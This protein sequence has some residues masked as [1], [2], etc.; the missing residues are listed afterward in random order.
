[1]ARKPKARLPG[2][3]SIFKDERGLYN[4]QIPLGKVRGRLQYK[5]I[6]C[7]TL[8]GLH[9]K[10]RE[11]EKR[12]ALGLV[13]TTRTPTV[14]TFLKDWLAQSVPARNRYS[15]ARAYQQIVRDYLIP[16]LGS[17]RLDALEPKHVQQMINAITAER[18]PR[19]VRNVRACLRRALNVARRDGLLIRNVAELVDVPKAEKSNIRTLDVTEARRLLD[20]VEQH[21]LKALYWTALLLGLREGELCGLRWADINLDEARLCITQSVQRQKHGDA[22]GKL[23]FVAPKTDSSVAPMPIPEV[24]IHILQEHQ[25][26]QDQERRAAQWQ[27]H[28]LV[29]PSEVGTPLEPRN[30]VRH[31][32]GVLTQAALPIIPFHHL[33]HTCGT[34][35]ME[36]GEHPRVIQA[37]LRHASFHTTMAFYAHAQPEIQREAVEGLGA[38]ISAPEQPPKRRGRKT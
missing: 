23:H 37:I 35:L 14:E 26:R 4:I 34:L 30:L 29:F 17:Y 19:T 7:K 12:L 1:M 11:F 5:R 25:A 8:E 38:L 13:S 21:R 31:F 6:R 22:A 36:S 24:L 15:T 9:E 3:G 27:E 16:H 33:R 2:E 28:G 10:R 18:A 32:K 20:A